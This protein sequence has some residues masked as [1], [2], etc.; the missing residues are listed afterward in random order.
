MSAEEA[1][2]VPGSVYA[3]SNIPLSMA[4]QG[5]A[6]RFVSKHV[7]AS[8]R[9]VSPPST[10]SYRC[11]KR[12]DIPTLSSWTRRASLQVRV[13]RRH[14]PAPVDEQGRRSPVELA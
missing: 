2:Q 14:V 13:A 5:M 3:C 12:L 1:M 6:S 4:M 8:D 7:E 9:Q 11:H 10:S